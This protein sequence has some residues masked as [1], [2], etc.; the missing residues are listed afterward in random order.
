MPQGNPHPLTH[1][2]RSLPGSRPIEPLVGLQR[3]NQQRVAE[4]NLANLPDRSRMSV[5]GH[6]IADPVW[7]EQACLPEVLRR[8]EILLLL[9]SHLGRPSTAQPKGPQ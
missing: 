4:G 5:E 8:P 7:V 3:F 9:R 6:H 1:E 2:Q